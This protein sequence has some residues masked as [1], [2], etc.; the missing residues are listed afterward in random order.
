MDYYCST[1]WCPYAP[2]NI[3]KV[4]AIQICVAC[5]LVLNDYFQYPGVTDM[6]NRLS[7]HPL[8][9]HRFL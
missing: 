8:Q 5:R 2:C 4:E 3:N 6:L 7:W 9:I 1:V